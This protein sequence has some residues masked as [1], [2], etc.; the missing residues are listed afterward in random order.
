MS[1]PAALL[2]LPFHFHNGL[3]SLLPAARRSGPAE[4][5]CTAHQS[6]KHLNEFH[7]CPACNQVYW[8]GSHYDHMLGMVKDLFKQ[9]KSKQGER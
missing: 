5:A 1:Q 8:K 2:N 3:E 7:L 6:I 4:L 9:G